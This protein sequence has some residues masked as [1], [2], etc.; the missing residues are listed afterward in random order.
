M[1][2]DQPVI[3]DAQAADEDGWRILWRDYLQF[4]DTELADP[5]TA[6]TWA[7]ILDPSSPIFAIVA[8]RGGALTG[9][10]IVV[11]HEASWSLT[12]VCYLEDLFVAPT[13]RGGGTGHALISELLDRA[14]AK[15]WARLYWHTL[16]GNAPA[17]RLYDRFAAADDFVRYRLTPP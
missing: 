13:A 8:E 16:A 4:Y 17:R 1:C 15:G 6:Q 7:R 10:A 11:L 14:T 5:V 2:Y 12:P 3:R 9:F